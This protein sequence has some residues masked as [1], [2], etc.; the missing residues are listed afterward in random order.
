M[1]FKAPQ[2][3]DSAIEYLV[4]TIVT[5]LSSSITCKAL[6]FHKAEFLCV[7]SGISSG[8]C[9]ELIGMC[10]DFLGKLEGHGSSIWRLLS[11]LASE[12]KVPIRV[13][14][15]SGGSKPLLGDV[16]VI[17]GT[18]F[19]AMS[20]VGEEFCVKKKDRIEVVAMLG[21]FGTLVSVSI[22]DW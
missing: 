4:K 13:F 2:V 7:G 18:L 10:V 16:L 19:F 12:G 5:V 11:S 6:R 21:L 20:N 8:D 3:F 22:L 17:A 14:A 9:A 15:D 1:C